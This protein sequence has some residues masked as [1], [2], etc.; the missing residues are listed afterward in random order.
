MDISSFLPLALITEPPTRVCSLMY[1]GTLLL[2]RVFV[3]SAVVSTYGEA[4]HLETVSFRCISQTRP[5]SPDSLLN[6][7]PPWRMWR[8]GLSRQ[9]LLICHRGT[10]A[11]ASSRRSLCT[12]CESPC[13]LDQLNIGGR[14]TRA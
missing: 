14:S 7:K 2:K 3:P 10:G 8:W 4:Q 12:M 13:F 5:L 11:V 9:R 1:S 6:A